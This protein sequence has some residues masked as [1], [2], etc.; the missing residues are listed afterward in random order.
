MA[1]KYVIYLDSRYPGTVRHN[2]YGYWSGK[3]Y[4][5]NGEIFPVHSRDSI[6][7]DTKKSTAELLLRCQEQNI[8]HINERC[9]VQKHCWKNAHM[10]GNTR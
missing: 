10:Y 7:C 3:T 9:K 4:T 5:V 2:S 1:K 6:T 8:R